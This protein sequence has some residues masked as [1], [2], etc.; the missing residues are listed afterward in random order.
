M[1]DQKT[2]KIDLSWIWYAIAFCVIS[3]L[4]FIESGT[5]LGGAIAMVITFLALLSSLLG[6]IP[7][8]GIL[9]HVFLVYPAITSAICG[10]QPTVQIPVT[11]LVICI[12][13]TIFSVILTI[14]AGLLVLV[15]L[16][17]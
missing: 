12:I 2:V 15:L 8:I 5:L 4:G 16:A 13:S 1:N 11:L 17:R 14:L 10:L 3:A 6:L 9:L 7:V